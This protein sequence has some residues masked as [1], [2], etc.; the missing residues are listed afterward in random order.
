MG[1]ANPFLLELRAP[2]LNPASQV[3]R[4]VPLS[5]LPTFP[6]LASGG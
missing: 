4:L 1:G 2:P 6:N 3:A 5:G